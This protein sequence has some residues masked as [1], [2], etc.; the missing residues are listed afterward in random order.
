MKPLVTTVRAIRELATGISPAAVASSAVLFQAYSPDADYL[1]TSDD[2]LNSQRIIVYR[3]RNVREKYIPDSL[4][5]YRREVLSRM[6]SLAERTQRYPVTLPKGW[7]QY[8]HNNLLAFFAVPGGGDPRSTR[9]IVEVAPGERPDVIYWKTTTAD[10]TSTLEEFEAEKPSL[11]ENLDDG[12]LQAHEDA[13]SHFAEIRNSTSEDVDMYLPSLTPA[14]I[15]NWSYD[16]WMHEISNDQ[17]AFID[18]GTSKSIRLRGPAGSGKTI[19]LQLK[20]VKEVLRAREAEEKVRVLFVTHSWALAAEVADSLDRMGVG[21]IHEIDTFPLLEIAQGIAP[22]FSANAAGLTLIGSDSHSSKQAQLDEIIELLDEFIEGDWI[23]YRATVSEPLRLRFDSKSDAERKALAWD[24]LVEFGSVIGAAAIFP[25]AGADSR[26]FQLQRAT[27]MLPLNTRA[28]KRVVFTLYSQYMNSLEARALVTSDQVLADALKNLDTHAWNHVRKQHGYDLIFVDEFHLFNPLE[29]QVIHYLTR[30]VSSYP[31]VFMAADPRQSPSEAFI[32]VAADETRSSTSA[33]TTDQLGD[34]DNFELTTV[35]RFSPQILDL[36]KHIH[37]EF[38]TFNLGNDW[39]VDF[40]K[41][42]SAQKDGP[43][44]SLV[45]SATRASEENDLSTAV[46]ELYPRGRVAIAVIDSRQWRRFSELTA[47][48]SQF[49][50]YH[51]TTISGRTD[52]EGLGY[53]RR[54]LIVGPAEYLAGL[55]FETVLV[56]GI[57]DLGATITSTE[58]NRLLSLMYLGISRAERE[59]RIFVNEDDGGPPEVLTRAVSKNLIQYL[60]G[61]LA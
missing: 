5:G 24:L 6:A 9:W 7:H 51:I 59:V 58:K 43:M 45:A 47:R 22:G 60:Q 29:R 49:A 50:K 31:R 34:V 26:Y 57:P 52:I 18:A 1:I 56:A 30:D 8:K 15:K 40:A 36:V 53:R 61:S 32:G 20:A 14:V 21:P 10:S 48:I 4:S 39:D 25:G 11:F 38:P 2:D 16:Q 3:D 44:P 54:G 35:H 28:D 19:A 46:H 23:T 13:Q 12:W 37:L 42:D 33:S 41:V 55:Q 17:R 27:W